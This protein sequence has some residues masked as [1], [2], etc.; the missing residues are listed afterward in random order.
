MVR[1][2]LKKLNKVEGE[3][4]YR[5]EMPNRFTALENVDTEVDV[6]RAWET[7]GWRMK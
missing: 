7:T 4:Q 3:E 6:N 5:V 1:V 2:N